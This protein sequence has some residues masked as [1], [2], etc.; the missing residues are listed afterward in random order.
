MVPAIHYLNG[1]DCRRQHDVSIR[2]RGLYN[3]SDSCIL[4]TSECSRTCALHERARLLI[5]AEKRPR[6]STMIRWLPVA[7]TVAVLGF[8]LA[9]ADEPDVRKLPPAAKEAI[10][11]VRDIK[12]L[13]ESRCAK[14]HAT[15]KPKGKFSLLTRDAALKTG[16]GGPN[17]LAGDSAKSK[18]IHY[19]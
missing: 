2:S 7:G 18:L 8:C 1:R 9:R 10:D 15:D 19:V 11:F 5:Q 14:C 16:D 17:I 6:S 4:D 3:A 13:L 12:P